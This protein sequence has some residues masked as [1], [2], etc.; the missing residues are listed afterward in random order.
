MHTSWI[1]RRC[2][3]LRNGEW[4][5]RQTIVHTTRLSGTE[6]SATSTTAPSR[7]RALLACTHPSPPPSPLAST[8]PSPASLDAAASS[9]ACARADFGFGRSALATALG[10]REALLAC[11]SRRRSDT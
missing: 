2:S 1:T 3:P 10:F 9:A 4:R 11:W 5:A 6:P 7:R 8:Q